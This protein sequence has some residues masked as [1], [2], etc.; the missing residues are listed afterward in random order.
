MAE[1]DLDESEAH[2]HLQELASSKRTKLID[3]AESI[4]RAA[5]L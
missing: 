3:I 2:K 5:G 4:V 1:K